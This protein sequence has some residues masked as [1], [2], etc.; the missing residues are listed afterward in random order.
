MAI[1]RSI[2]NQKTSTVLFAVGQVAS[3]GASIAADTEEERE[4]IE[5]ASD[6][7]YYRHRVNQHERE[8]QRR[9]LRDQRQ[10]WELEALRKTDLF[11]NE[12]IRG[13][14]FFK[15]V[16]DANGYTILFNIG[17]KVFE[18]FYRQEKYEVE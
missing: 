7:S 2:A 5:E 17:E 3:V 8:L 13:Y 18:V 15:N 10:V 11:P 16:S 1:S 12:Y 4:E 6:E 14:L 9:G